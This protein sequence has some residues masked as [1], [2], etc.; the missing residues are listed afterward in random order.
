MD[1]QLTHFLIFQ[2]IE[3]TLTINKFKVITTIISLYHIGS[4]YQSTDLIPHTFQGVPGTNHLKRFSNLP[5]I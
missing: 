5:N 4:K 1:E 2:F 3:L